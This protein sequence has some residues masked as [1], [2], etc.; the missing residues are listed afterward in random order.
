MKVS[1]G[2]ERDCSGQ[3]DFPTEQPPGF[4]RQTDAALCCLLT[5]L[6]HSSPCTIHMQI[7]FCA[8]TRNSDFSKSSQR[9]L[10]WI[11]W[12]GLSICISPRVA[13]WFSVQH[14]LRTTGSI[15][16]EL[17]AGPN[18]KSLADVNEFEILISK[19]PVNENQSLYIQ[20][21]QRIQFSL[22][23]LQSKNTLHLSTSRH[24]TK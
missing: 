9:F 20:F 4:L 16:N 2:V 21:N 13:N 18:M 19:K 5:G 15:L 14:N 3:E 7:S 22:P 8:G 23:I 12:L 24:S 11:H 6:A 17:T 10:I 1:I